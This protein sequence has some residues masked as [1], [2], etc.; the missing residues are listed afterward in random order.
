MKSM[1]RPGLYNKGHG[2]KQIIG[3]YDLIVLISYL[4]TLMLM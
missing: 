2:N 1:V 4:L 3:K